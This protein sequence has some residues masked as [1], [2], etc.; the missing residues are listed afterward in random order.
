MSK[1]DI[2]GELKKANPDINYIISLFSPNNMSSLDQCS[3]VVRTL[4][5]FLFLF[6][7]DAHGLTGIEFLTRVIRG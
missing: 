4:L 5:L 7:S 3:S 1:E 2:I 6:I